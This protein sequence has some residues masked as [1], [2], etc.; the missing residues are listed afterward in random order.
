LNQSRGQTD[1]AKQAG[2]PANPEGEV[3]IGVHD[4][5]ESMQVLKR[6]TKELNH[7]ISSELKLVNPN[8]LE[9]SRLTLLNAGLCG[10]WIET[11]EIDTTKS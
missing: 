8:S 9:Y 6:R 2:D 5:L 4:L 7:L 10:S 1:A 3:R 11:K